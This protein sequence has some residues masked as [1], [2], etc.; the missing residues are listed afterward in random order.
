MTRNVEVKTCERLALSTETKRRL[1]SESGGYCQNPQ[2]TTKQLFAAGT[3]IDFAEMAHIIPASTG[4]PRDESAPDMTPQQRAHHSNVAVLCANCHT[5]V[6]KDPASYPADLVRGWK[7]RHARA[8]EVALGAPEFATRAEARDYVAPKLDENRMIFTHYGPLREAVTEEGAAQWRRHVVATVIPNNANVQLALK[9]NRAL[10][11]PDE[12]ATADLFSLH[13]FE[14][15]ARHLLDD[16]T[17]G[18]T[19][20]PVAMD[21][22]LKDTE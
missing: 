15:E 17:A 14:F 12:Q 10:L 8:L 13:V 4:G 5:I 18:S 22:I 1:W 9:R 6:D 16:F 19:R 21:T 2:C 11:T 3:D 20:F 7:E